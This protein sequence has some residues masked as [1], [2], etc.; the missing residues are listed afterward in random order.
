M[1]CEVSMSKRLRTVWECARRLVPLVVTI[2]PLVVFGCAAHGRAGQT[3]NQPAAVAQSGDSAVPLAPQAQVNIAYA[4]RRDWLSSLT[5]TKYSGAGELRPEAAGGN[6]RALL[7]RFEGGA[8]IWQIDADRTLLSGVPLFGK[9][10]QY[11]PAEVKYGVVPK[12]FVQSIPAAG[13]SEPL[14]ADH[15]YVFAATRGSDSASYE[16]VKVRAD[17]SLE[18]YDAQPRAGSSYRLCCEVDADFTT[19]ADSLSN[20]GAAAP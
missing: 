2:A 18:V 1:T 20:T 19:A 13:P 15:F 14:E 17:G 4:R 8:V 7:V 10:N 3:A 6:G 5:V 9:G 11:A 16:A 12:G